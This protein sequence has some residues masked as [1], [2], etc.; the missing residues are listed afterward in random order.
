MCA[1]LTRQISAWDS[2]PHSQNSQSF[3][4]YFKKSAGISSVTVAGALLVSQGADATAK[5]AE[6]RT[7][8]HHAVMRGHLSCV[9]RLINAAGGP[10]ALLTPDVLGCT[11]IHLGALQNQVT[12]ILMLVDALLKD[13]KGRTPLHETARRHC[14]QVWWHGFAHCKFEG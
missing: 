9:Q 11:P 12:L 4:R 1:Q 3:D 5:D 7:P 10:A 6:G 8:L 14:L 13:T 2:P